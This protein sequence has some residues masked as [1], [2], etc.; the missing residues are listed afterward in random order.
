M[1]LERAIAQSDRSEGSLAVLYLDLDHFKDINDIL[2]HR[3]GDLLLKEVS[4]RLQAQVRKNDTVARFGGDEFAVIMSSLDDPEDAAGLSQKLL[5][6]LEEPYFI[7][8]NEI[9]SGTS[10]GIATYG[11]RLPGC[12]IADHTR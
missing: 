7:Q 5:E 6:V 12:R 8:G 10:I 3:V 4:G 9:R 11:A 1:R 2:G